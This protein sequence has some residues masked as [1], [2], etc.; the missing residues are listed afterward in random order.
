MKKLAAITL[1]SMMLLLATAMVVGA[2]DNVE[3]RGQV[4]T[5]NFE[6]NAQ[7]F[8]GFYYD[9]DDAL[10]TEKITTT[11]TEGQ[12]PGTHWRTPTPQPSRRTTST[13]PTGD[14]TTLSDSRLTSTSLAT[15]TTRTS[16][17]PMRS[18]SRNPPMRTPCLTSSSKPS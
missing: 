7:N 4:A 16:M 15:S 2:V 6:W 9:I 12:A 18:C 14:S 13:S 1:T 8:A 10:G 11:I 17:M 5:G 3:I